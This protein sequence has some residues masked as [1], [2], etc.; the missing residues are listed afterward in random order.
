M[1]LLPALSYRTSTFHATRFI[2][3]PQ[4]SSIVTSLPFLAFFSIF[5]HIIIMSGGGLSNFALSAAVVLL[6]HAA[7]SLQHYR[8]LVHDLQEEGHDASTTAL[9]A[10]PPDVRIELGLSF[11]IL[12]LS[13]LLRVV[14][15]PVVVRPGV[16][17]KS[18]G[19]ASNLP[20]P[21]IT[22]GFDTY[23]NRARGFAEKR[24]SRT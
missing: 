2:L 11:G 19:G 18:V 22:R 10:I 17:V 9:P 8:S 21:Y 5:H 23:T 14:L 20:P 3:Q 1:V 6:L 7:Y 13:E 24:R 12:L 4:L 16:A 15:T